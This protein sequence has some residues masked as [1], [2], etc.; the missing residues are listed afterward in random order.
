ANLAEL[1]RN[2]SRAA[3]PD[4]QVRIE[5]RMGPQDGIGGAHYVQTHQIDLGV[6]LEHQRNKVLQVEIQLAV[7]NALL[8]DL[9]VAQL[10]VV[11]A[12]S[13]AQKSGRGNGKS[14]GTEGH[15]D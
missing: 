2:V 15:K 14:H 1:R 9:H 4:R 7:V 5:R 11:S 8:D 3:E 10:D 12:E 13:F 6:V